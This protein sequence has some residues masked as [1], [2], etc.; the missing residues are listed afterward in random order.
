[1]SFNSI[2]RRT[3]IVATIGPATQ[4]KEILRQLILAGA[5]TLR[6]NFSHGD[7][8]YHKHS[9]RLIRQTAYELNQPVA[10]LQDLQGPKIRLG[11][12]VNGPITLKPGD[13]FILTSRDVECNQ[14][15]S[16][17]SYEYLSQEVPEQARILMDDGKVE[18]RVE[19][20]DKEN[21]DLHCQVVVGG[22]CLIV[23]G[24]TFQGFIYPL[25]H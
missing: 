25:K 15:I 9:I 12:F 2:A 23:R 17:I 3:K 19:R 6:L 20:V 22:C 8:D 11:K 10:I 7:H 18:M 14:T 13:P 24:S 21:K 16:S 5:T 1:M 4:N